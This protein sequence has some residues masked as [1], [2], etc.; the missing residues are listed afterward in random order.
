M[1][2]MYIFMGLIVVAIGALIF[3][4]IKWGIAAKSAMAKSHAMHSDS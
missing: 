1:T 3:M 4:K 2:G